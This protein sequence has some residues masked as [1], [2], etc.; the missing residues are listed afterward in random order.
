MQD[1]LRPCPPPLL[2]LGR[3]GAVRK[4]L[5]QLAVR[6]HVDGAQLRTALDGEL[7]GGAGSRH[8]RW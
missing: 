2:D 8:S 5:R 3:C 4:C 6:D 1:R 7:D